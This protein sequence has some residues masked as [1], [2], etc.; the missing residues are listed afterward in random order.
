VNPL[1]QTSLVEAEV[2]RRSPR[3][4]PRIGVGRRRFA[5]ARARAVPGR[6]AALGA[7]VVAAGERGVVAQGK[8]L[9]QRGDAAVCA[10]VLEQLAGPAEVGQRSLA[11]PRIDG[12]TQA[13]R[14]QRQSQRGAEGGGAVSLGGCLER[15]DVLRCADAPA[16]DQQASP[17]ID[18]APLSSSSG[19]STA[20]SLSV[21]GASI[22]TVTGSLIASPA[23]SICRRARTWYSPG[24]LKTHP[25]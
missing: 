18:E 20:R 1:A 15:R 19:C 23:A 7:R 6:G 8:L 24:F 16:E 5:A 2:Q 21:A 3:L 4:Q 12:R 22:R 25:C 17:A 10:G 13:L 9:A 14:E 11:G